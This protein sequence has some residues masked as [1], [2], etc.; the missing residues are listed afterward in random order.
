MLCPI[1]LQ[2]MLFQWVSATVLLMVEDV[3]AC[4][5]LPL[6]LSALLE[7]GLFSTVFR[8]QRG[9]GKP[10]SEWFLFSVNF[11]K[12]SDNVQHTYRQSVS[13]TFFCPQSLWSEP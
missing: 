12:T 8:T 2:N 13:F 6:T 4:A 1:C 11:A 10:W 7:G 9:L 3:V 5:N